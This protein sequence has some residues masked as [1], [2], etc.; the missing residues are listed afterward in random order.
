MYCTA[1]SKQDYI[2]RIS[3][4][5]PLLKFVNKLTIKIFVTK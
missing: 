1:E 5:K 2:F 3:K 4:K